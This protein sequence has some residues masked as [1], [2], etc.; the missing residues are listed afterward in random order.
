MPTPVARYTGVGGPG[1]PEGAAGH[2]AE[3]LVKVYLG[4]PDHAS[5]RN[6][7]PARHLGSL[8]GARGDWRE[9]EPIGGP[10][11]RGRPAQM[12]FWESVPMNCYV[13]PRTARSG[14]AREWL[15]AGRE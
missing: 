10:D 4:V 2:D 5:R 12:S 14:R 1:H 9:E 11:R 6:R 15:G 7:N 8:G 13:G 3:P